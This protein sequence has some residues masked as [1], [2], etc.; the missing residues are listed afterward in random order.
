MLWFFIYWK[1]YETSLMSSRG[2]INPN[3]ACRSILHV[4]NLLVENVFKFSMLGFFM[5]SYFTRWD[6]DGVLTMKLTI[7][8]LVLY[9]IS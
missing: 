3:K 1:K 9:F 5:V 7:L 4:L 8:F 2:K 6:L